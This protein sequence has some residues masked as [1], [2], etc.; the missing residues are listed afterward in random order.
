MSDDQDP[1]PAHL[2]GLRRE[3]LK[4]SEAE[5]RLVL[6][7]KVFPMLHGMGVVARFPEGGEPLVDIDPVETITILRRRLKPL[8]QEKLT[9]FIR[10]E[11]MP[12]LREL[13]ETQEPSIEIDEEDK[14]YIQTASLGTILKGPP[15]PE[16]V[17]AYNMA[18]RILGLK[19]LSEH[20]DW[21]LTVEDNIILARVILEAGAR[22]CDEGIDLDET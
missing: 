7:M 13:R 14:K 16:S 3:L 1:G 22:A 8:S 10:N 5:R 15:R 18:A 21:L 17:E 20:D 9:E 4:L 12:L 19:Q 6:A 2:E 11:W